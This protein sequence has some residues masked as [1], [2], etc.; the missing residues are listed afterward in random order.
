MML[1]YKTILSA[2]VALGAFC[3]PSSA[4]EEFVMGKAEYQLACAIC[5]GDSAKGDGEMVRYLNIKPANLTQLAKANGGKYPFMKVFETID[6]RNVVKTHGEG[7]M[8]IWGDRY[9]VEAGETGGSIPR[10]SDAEYVRGR[11]LELTYY[12]QTLQE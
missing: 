1:R 4:A 8:P 11:I 9:K 5:H 10:G 12:L 7:P 2:L 6:G 3:A